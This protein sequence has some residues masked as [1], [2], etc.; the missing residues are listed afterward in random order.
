MIFFIKLVKITGFFYL[1]LNLEL[2]PI[3]IF[4]LSLPLK[5][6]SPKKSLYFLVSFEIWYEEKIVSLLFFEKSLIQI[7]TMGRSPFQQNHNKLLFVLLLQLLMLLMF[8]LNIPLQVFFFTTRPDHKQN[9]RYEWVSLRSLHNF[10]Y[11]KNG[12]ECFKKR[13][14]ISELQQRPKS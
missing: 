4:T 2:V 1:P 12:S 13:F 7:W 6:C 5:T 8:F 11:S 9:D 14:W 10:F 3:N